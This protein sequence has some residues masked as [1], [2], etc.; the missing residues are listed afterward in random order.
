MYPSPGANEAPS[1]TPGASPVCSGVEVVAAEPFDVESQTALQRDPFVGLVNLGGR[2]A[3][4]EI[5][6]GGEPAVEREPVSAGGIE[7]L[8]AQAEPDRGLGAALRANHARRAAAGPVAER[9][10]LEQN[11]LA[12]T[13]FREQDGGPGTDGA[14]AD[15]HHV[16]AG[17]TGHSTKP[18][19]RLNAQSI[20]RRGSGCLDVRSDG[21]GSADPGHCPYDSSIR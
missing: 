7:L 10:R 4:H 15:H 13:S 20:G 3:R 11:D 18:W 16:G 6:L 12:R 21:G 1:V 19:H 8:G 14:A 17:G 9:R 5:A 2:E